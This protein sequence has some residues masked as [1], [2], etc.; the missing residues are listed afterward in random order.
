MFHSILLFIQNYLI[1]GPHSVF[2]SATKKAQRDFRCKRGPRAAK[3]MFKEA[4]VIFTSNWI[5]N[6][7]NK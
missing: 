5:L 4:K 2:K 7:A 6:G 3:K 1:I